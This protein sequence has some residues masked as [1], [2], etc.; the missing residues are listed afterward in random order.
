MSGFG[1][2]FS[3]FAVNTSLPNK[4]GR[5]CELAHVLF[6]QLKRKSNK[7]FQKCLSF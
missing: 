1:H 2:L 6:V 7:N 5:F 3:D 4:N